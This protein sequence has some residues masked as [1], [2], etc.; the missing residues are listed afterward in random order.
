MNKLIPTELTFKQKL[1]AR[2]AKKGGLRACVNAHCCQCIY[3]EL[4]PG[5]WRKQVENCTV[6]DCALYLKRPSTTGSRH[7]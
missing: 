1:V 2:I 4:V 7:G 3:D 6:E 5:T